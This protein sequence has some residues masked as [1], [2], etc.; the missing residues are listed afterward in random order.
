MMPFDGLILLTGTRSVNRHPNQIRWSFPAPVAHTL[1]RGVPSA[2]WHRARARALTAAVCPWSLG[3]KGSLLT[4][5]HAPSLWSRH[6]LMH[7]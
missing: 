4:L 3:F 5:A 6:T 7:H 1:H 2:P